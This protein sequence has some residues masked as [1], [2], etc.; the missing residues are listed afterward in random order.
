MAATVSALRVVAPVARVAARK[1]T[2]ART[3]LV[4]KVRAPRIA[5]ARHILDRRREE[6]RAPRS[7]RTWRAAPPLDSR[8]RVPR[9]APSRL[10]AARD[11][12]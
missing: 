5:I 2:A 11:R 7:A 9:D 10:R 1:A 3:A 8:A 6:A 12:G 4:V